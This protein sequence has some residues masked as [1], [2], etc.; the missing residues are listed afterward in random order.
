MWPLRNAALRAMAINDRVSPKRKWTKACPCLCFFITFARGR[1][2]LTLPRLTRKTRRYVH[3][4][5][6]NV[7]NFQIRHKD[8]IMAL[9][10]WRGLLLLYLC[11]RFPTTFKSGM[12]HCSST[13]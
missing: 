3:L 8:C 6:E 2:I 10:L 4:V 9:T 1:G 12:W 11:L 7:G 13:L 5:L